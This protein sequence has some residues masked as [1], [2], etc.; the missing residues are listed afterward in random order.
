MANSY[1]IELSEWLKTRE[2][3]KR[4]KNR[5]LVAFLAIRED[6][7]EALDKGYSRRSIWEHLSATGKVSYRYEA[8]LKHVRRHITDIPPKQTIENN[9]QPTTPAPPQAPKPLSHP[10]Q[11]SEKPQTPTLR[12]EL[13][14]PESTRPGFTFNP[15]ANP[16]ELY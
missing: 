8:F 6:I 12:P 15:V 13:A 10:T 4:S 1:T 2:H 14:R 5:N 3:N 11:T 16:D 7:R 9:R